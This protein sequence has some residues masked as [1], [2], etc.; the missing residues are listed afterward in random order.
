MS[1]TLNPIYNLPIL[2]KQGGVIS[3]STVTQLRVSSCLVRGENDELDINI[4][5]YFGAQDGTTLDGAVNG[6]NGLDTGSLAASKVYAVFAIADAAGFNPPGFLLSLSQTSPVMPNGSFSSGYNVK[7]RIGWAVTNGSSQFAKL[8]VSGQ[9]DVVT[10][11]YDAP[12]VVLA[13]GAETSQTAVSLA[14][15]VPAV[16][17][18]PVS[19]SAIFN[20]NAAN[21]TATLCPSGATIASSKY[22][23]RAPVAGATAVLNTT[24]TMPAL[25]I[26]S[27]PK[28]DYVVSAGTD[29][30]ALYVTGFTDLL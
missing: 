26:S 19:L 10:Y 28:I 15:A 11:T 30:L 29:A 4:G 12:V 23:L 22:I 21:D 16:D 24:L 13:G 20:A 6:L 17:G 27:L 18:I 7:R 5:D 1:T 9:S 8:Y 25:L 3:Y 2:Y 14:A